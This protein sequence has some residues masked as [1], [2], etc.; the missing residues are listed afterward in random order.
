MYEY[1]AKVVKVVDGDT[2]DVDIDLGFDVL[3]E[4]TKEC[5]SW[6]LIHPKARTR[7]K[8][9]KTIWLGKQGQD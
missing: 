8:V 1:R 2:V 9:E 6:A 7:D 5:A 4:R 3:D